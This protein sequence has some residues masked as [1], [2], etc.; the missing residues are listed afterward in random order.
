MLPELKNSIVLI[1]SRDQNTRNFGTGF[2]LRRSSAAVYVLTC[3]HVVKDVGGPEQINVD[4][5]PATVAKSGEAEGIDLAVLKVEGLW[6]KPLLN[7]KRVGEKGRSVITVG[8][9][10]Y[11]RSRLLRPLKGTLGNQVELQS[12]QTSDRIQAWDLQ[13]IDDHPL[14]PGYSGS[15]VVDRETGEVL[16]V[17]S[18]RQG[19]GESGLAI[20]ISA[21]EKIWPIIDSNQVY[22]I[23]LKLG[24]WQ[25]VRQFK[26]LINTHSVAAL[27]IH[28]EPQSGQRWLLNRLVSQH[29]RKSLTSSPVVVDFDSPVR[30]DDVKALWRVLAWKVGL[31]GQAAPEEIIKKVYKLWK[32]QNVLIV[33]HKIDLLP[34]PG[35]RV[36]ELIE[37]FWLPLAS[38]A[39][40][41]MKDNQDYKLLM[42]LVDYQGKVGKLN[43]PF[44]EKLDA[45][46][47]PQWPLLAPK[48]EDFSDDELRDWLE[49]EGDSL[50]VDFNNEEVIIQEILKNSENGI[51]ELVLQEIC[52]RC[53]CDWY[54]ELEKLWKKL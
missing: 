31:K 54:E 24:Y 42:F 34:E 52:D 18:H 44:I 32:T 12:S 53:D 4:G 41:A 10:Q 3:A 20:S 35:L 46:W 26:K 29:V 38:Q 36:S 19:Q 47:N 28:G 37:N 5:I 39:R 27:L 14:K 43:L 13:I 9:Q 15:P 48:I 50:P 51:P 16:A 6:Y 30:R 7:R 11:D 33:L 21:L 17:V 23:L 2:V 1:T 45:V 40:E 8:F 22:Q 25:Q 49:H